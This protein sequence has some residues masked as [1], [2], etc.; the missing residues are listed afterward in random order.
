[1]LSSSKTPL[2][3]SS[4]ALARTTVP[5]PFPPRVPSPSRENTPSCT[6]P[7]PAPLP[8]RR[9]RTPPLRHPPAED[10]SGSIPYSP[11][12]MLQ[13]VSATSQSSDRTHMGLSLAKSPR[14]THTRLDFA[15]T[16]I[17]CAWGSLSAVESSRTVADPRTRPS[18]EFHAHRG[19]SLRLHASS[20]S[21]SPH[22]Y[23]RDTHRSSATSYVQ[24]LV[25]SQCAASAAG[26]HS[27]KRQ[28]QCRVRCAHPHPSLTAHASEVA[29]R[30][31][32]MP[33]R[34]SQ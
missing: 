23:V 32:S 22:S 27:G 8:W 7:S 21:R 10:S 24:N 28:L 13:K 20:L 34:P 33:Q 17:P 5:F 2:R 1:M 16:R 12:S 31:Q 9:R 29:N 26:P 14:L 15:S 18:S 3:L 6:P 25:A 11:K 4:G 30:P 19:V